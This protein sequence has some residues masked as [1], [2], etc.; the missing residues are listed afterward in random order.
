MIHIYNDKRRYET[1]AN[2]IY[3]SGYLYLYEISI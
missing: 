3:L 2:T 1:D